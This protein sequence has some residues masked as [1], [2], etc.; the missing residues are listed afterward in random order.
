MPVP[1]SDNLYSALD[2]GDDDE[3]TPSH[4]DHPTVNTDS[5]TQDEQNGA[6][7]DQPN[8]DEALSPSD[9]YF[10]ASDATAY[11]PPSNRQ[12]A[13][14]PNVPNVLVDDPTLHDDDR[15]TKTREAENERRLSNMAAL[16][17]QQAPFQS[18]G[19][20][21]GQQVQS[22]IA[23]SSRPG[24]IHRR[25]V[26]EDQDLDQFHDNSGHTSSSPSV[27]Q[28]RRQDH[29]QQRHSQPNITSPLFQQQPIDAPPAYTPS[30][31][32]QS[33]GDDASPRS[34]SS[35][36]SAGLGYQTFGSPPA[37]AGDPMGVPSEH[38]RLLEERA[39]N[40]RL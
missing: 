8:E 39:C 28:H 35:T 1:Y 18:P 17:D 34:P 3:Y 15:D 40:V 37:T 10:H 11:E 21:T 9:G 32:S 26:D 12:S 31:P 13:N 22:P 25:S 27:S 4:T 36:N 20:P 29:Q 5:N 7:N 23:T 38:Q 24:H 30:A 19:S 16:Q 14:V 2:D 33:Q 6:G